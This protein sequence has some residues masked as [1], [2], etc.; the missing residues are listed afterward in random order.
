MYKK[1][2]FYSLLL[3]SFVI[4][5]DK[6][7]FDAPK[8]AIPN[9]ELHINTVVQKIKTNN[10]SGFK[11]MIMPE[12]IFDEMKKE[13]KIE[14]FG[15]YPGMDESTAEL[16]WSLLQDSE[17]EIWKEYCK[18]LEKDFE[19]IQKD[20][21]NMNEIEIEKIQ[22]KLVG[23]SQ[24]PTQFRCNAK[25]FVNVGPKKYCIKYKNF[26]F[27]GG[28]WYVGNLTKVDELPDSEFE[29]MPDLYNGPSVDEYIDRTEELPIETSEE[30]VE[31]ESSNEDLPKMEED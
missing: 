22:W 12:E 6:A 7:F 16:A 26:I 19:D 25:I 17:M 1:I 13:E 20:I 8:N 2:I 30:A 14:F 29:Y 4:L 21:P 18:E 3:F 23:N 24:L 27:Y 31:T 5:V 28:K 10:L 15:G 11:N 9:P